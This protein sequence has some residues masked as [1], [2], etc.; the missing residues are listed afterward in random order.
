MNVSQEVMQ[1]KNFTLEELSDFSAIKSTK[2]KISETNPNL[3]KS[4]TVCQSIDKSS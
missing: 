4:M 1:M 3:E 2:D